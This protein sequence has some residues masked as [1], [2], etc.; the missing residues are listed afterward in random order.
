[1]RVLKMWRVLIVALAAAAALVPTSPDRI[2]RLYSTGAYP[3]LQRAATALS[4]TVPFALF[5]ALL[6]L[7]IGL[8]VVQAVRELGP[9]ARRRRGVF[10]A[11]LRIAGRTVVWAA[12]LYLA[13]LITWGLNYRRTPLAAK[14]QV[15][16]NAVTRD[17]ALVL[18]MTS[19]D[20]LNGLYS[21][22]H[23]AGFPS[24]VQVDPVL[25]GAL[26]AADRQLG[27]TGLVAVGRPKA[28]LLD[29]YFRRTATDGMTDP[30]FLETLVS[31]TLLPFERPFVV[32][33]EWS[34][35]AGVADEGDANF[36]AWLAC[37]HASPAAQYSG[38]LFLY[39]EVASGLD[40]RARTQLAPR[41]DAGPRADLIAIRTRLEQQISP[42]LASFSRLLYDR[43]LKANRV[44]SGVRSYGHVVQLVLGARFDPGWTPRPRRF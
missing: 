3:P 33:H 27:G 4:N 35:L 15:D 8:W 28:T 34:H 44:E 38:W 43:Y 32:A 42:Q 41:L 1:L 24:A 40:A 36:L 16:P 13:F 30:Y 21:T 6:V 20:Q 17:A 22:A 25:A 12:V 23:A 19:V 5:D 7:V 9:N 26:A 14:L 11:A 29:W 39:A 10:S 18:A 2:E 37:V 31:T